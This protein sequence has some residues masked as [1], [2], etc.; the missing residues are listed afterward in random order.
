MSALVV[1]ADLYQ[2]EGLTD[3]ARDKLLE[4]SQLS[5]DSIIIFGLAEMEFELGNFEQAIHYYAKLDNRELLEATGVST[6]NV[7]VK[8]MLVLVSL[9]LLENFWKKL[10]KLNTMILLPLN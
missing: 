10:L 6:M 9:K 5:D 8:L 2:M 3:V 4:A 1:K 7:L